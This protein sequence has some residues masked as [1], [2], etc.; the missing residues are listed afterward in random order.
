MKLFEKYAPPAGS[1]TTFWIRQCILCIRGVV[2]YSVGRAWAPPTWVRKWTKSEEKPR[3]L[4]IL[5]VL[6]A[7]FTLWATPTFL[8]KL[9]ICIPYCR[10]LFADCVASLDSFCL[11]SGEMGNVEPIIKVEPVLVI[12]EEPDDPY[13]S[14]AE[15][16]I[17]QRMKKVFRKSLFLWIWLWIVNYIYTFVLPSLIIYIRPLRLRVTSIA[18]IALSSNIRYCLSVFLHCF[19]IDCPICC[20]TPR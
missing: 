16:N 14:T 4:R 6:W 5:D 19:P 9:H 3:F 7:L 13:S 2:T 10:K 18:L 8:T 11:I 12:K 20:V 15:G 1:E 17:I